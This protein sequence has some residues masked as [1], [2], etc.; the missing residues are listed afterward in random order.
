MFTVQ[1]YLAEFKREQGSVYAIKT[2][3]KVFLLHSINDIY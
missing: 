1:V 3:D 2:V